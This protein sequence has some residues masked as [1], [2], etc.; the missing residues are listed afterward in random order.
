MKCKF[1][2]E[3]LPERGNFCPICG[4]DNTLAEA[5]E[6]EQAVQAMAEE[7]EQV[8]EIVPPEDWPFEPEQSEEME[9]AVPEVKKMK[10]IAI[11]S[12]CVALLAVLALVLFLGIRGTAGQ[13]GAGVSLSGLFD[14]GIFKEN[15]I[16]K[17]DSYTVADDKAI[18]KADKVVATLGDAKLTN[19]QLQ[20]YYQMEVIEFL[21]YYSYYLSYIGLDY[22][23]PLDQQECMMMEGYTWQQ[24]FLESALSTWQQNQ[25]LAMEA[26]KNNFQLDSQ[27]A[28]QLETLESN[29]AATAVTNGFASA[30]AFL[31]AQCGA[32]TDMADYKSYM[33]TYFNGYLYFAQ[34]SNALEV[35]S[36]E[37]LADYFAANKEELEANSI[38]QDGS[39]TIDVR[40]ILIEVEGGVENEDG[41]ITF[42]DEALAAEAYAKAQSILNQWLENPT[43][44]NFGALAKEHTADGNG[45]AG[46]LYTDVA[47]GDM[48]ATF[49]DWCFDAARQPGDYGIVTTKFGYHIMYFSARGEDTW[50]SKTR[51][52][53]MSKMEASIL[54]ELMAKYDL[55][56]D[57]GKIA[58]T[59]V[60]LG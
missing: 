42:P 47:A 17:K 9:T 40:H 3:E 13:D 7:T 26:K 10:R 55:E 48:V 45:D 49:N 52:Y 2:G 30:D 11:I 4:R 12:G 46:G 29:M 21:N 24:F 20:V 5:L 31:Q 60:D 18:R 41:T 36:D 59:H 25:A 43:E 56:V 53:Y 28:Q 34:L 38:K 37:A 50:L 32:N 54:E 51:D 16:F 19:G 35:P 33:E 44:E 27:Y 1:C 57:Y 39:Y 23:Q 15:D 14:W 22:T 8:V 58:L 6:E